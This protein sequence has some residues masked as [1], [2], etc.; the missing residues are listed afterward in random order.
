[1]KIFK[2]LFDGV[3]SSGA[4]V[5][6]KVLLV[7]SNEQDAALCSATLAKANFEVRRALNCAES[8][9]LLTSGANFQA[10]V[11]NFYLSDGTAVQILNY[12]KEHSPDTIAIV[13]APEVEEN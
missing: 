10:I 5:R 1:M 7:E 12:A 13:V 3:G 4:S 9:R 8:F 2:K 6:E 11:T